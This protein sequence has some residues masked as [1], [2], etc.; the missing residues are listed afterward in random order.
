MTEVLD[1]QRPDAWHV[2][3]QDRREP[4]EQ[5]NGFLFGP[6]VSVTGAGAG[7]GL[8]EPDDHVSAER[9]EGLP[10]GLVSAYADR[11]VK[12]VRI[13]EVDPGVFVATVAG[14][15]GAYGDGDSA[16]EAK[17]DLREAIVGWVAVK[18]RLN[19]PIPVLEGLDLNV[20]P[21]PGPA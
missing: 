17:S 14:L 13:Q 11:A 5:P 16:E 1:T 18:R 15:E 2:L 3:T 10:I 20:P 4:Q 21:R 9:V 19:L 6:Q 12:H 7:T 8:A